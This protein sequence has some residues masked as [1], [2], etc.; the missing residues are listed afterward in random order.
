MTTIFT[1]GYFGWGNATERLVEAVDAVE[2]VR[3][4]GPPLFVDIRIRRTVRAIGFQGTAFERL[5]GPSRHRWMKSLGNRFIQTRIGPEIQIADPS[6]ADELLDDAMDAARQRQRLLF[7]CGCQWPRCAGKITCHRATVAGLLIEAAKKRRL[8]IEVVEWP[9]GAPRGIGLSV[10]PKLYSAIQKGRLSI[11]LG[12][13]ADAADTVRSGLSG[14]EPRGTVRS[15]LSGTGPNDTLDLADIA[16]LPWG[17]IAT[18]HAD[19]QELHRI[20]GPARWRNDQWSLPVLGRIDD[21][22]ASQ[23]EYLESAERLRRYWGL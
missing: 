19:G 8:P 7:F 20:V 16:G 2:Q 15:G 5:L 13:P 6:A 11:L 4:F 21:A 14:T 3:G 17:S 10:N 18:L 9:G 22:A 1:W 12:P 23:K